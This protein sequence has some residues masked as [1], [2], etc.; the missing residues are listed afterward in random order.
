M[1]LDAI[2]HLI[3]LLPVVNRNTLHALLKFL[4]NMAKFSE[5]TKDSYGK[6]HFYLY[7]LFYISI[8]NLMAYNYHYNN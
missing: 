8:K 2:K 7:H 1:Q 4:N 6:N 5:D 3:Q